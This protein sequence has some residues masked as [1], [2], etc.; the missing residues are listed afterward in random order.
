MFGIDIDITVCIWRA[1][2]SLTL[3]IVW[4]GDFIVFQVSTSTIAACH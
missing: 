1:K 4:S 3:H 2:Q